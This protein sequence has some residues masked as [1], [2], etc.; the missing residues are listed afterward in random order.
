[1]ATAPAAK[2]PAAANPA[3]ATT[4]SETVESTEVHE[5]RLQLAGL[6]HEVERTGRQVYVAAGVAV[7][8]LVGLVIWLAELR[9]AAIRAYASVEQLSVDAVPGVP[10]EAE[11]RFR[12]TSPGKLE[13]IR[14]AGDQTET[15]IEHVDSQETTNLQ[16]RSFRWSREGR[17]YTIVFR[18]RE[19]GRIKESSFGPPVDADLTKGER[20]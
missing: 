15:L 7:L 1:V 13:I 17:D 10:D 12:P 8:L 3:S 2:S 11:I 19:N 6:A 20:F 9:A 4:G 14:R 5:L 18:Y 16:A